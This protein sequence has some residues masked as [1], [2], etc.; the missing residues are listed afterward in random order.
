M[1]IFGTA[2]FVRLARLSAAA[3]IGTIG[4]LTLA[5]VGVVYSIYYRLAPWLHHIEISKYVAIEHF[6]AFAIF[7]ALC[8]VAFPRRILLVSL[9]VFGSVVCLE[10]LQNLTPDRHGTFFDAVQKVAGG[11]FGILASEMIAKFWRIGRSRI[12]K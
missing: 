2:Q 12:A 11:A 4:Y 3:L 8:C 5:R 1:I 7:G 10:L 6:V 9:V